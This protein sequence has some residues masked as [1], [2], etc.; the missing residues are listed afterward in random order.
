MPGRF[1]YAEPFAS[2]LGSYEGSTVEVGVSE[3]TR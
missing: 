1:R 2:F 3:F